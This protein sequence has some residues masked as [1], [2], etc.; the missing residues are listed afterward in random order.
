MPCERPSLGSETVAFHVRL[1]LCAVLLPAL[2]PHRAVPWYPR[3]ATSSSVAEF[4]GSA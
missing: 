3:L 2:P 1:A 4:S